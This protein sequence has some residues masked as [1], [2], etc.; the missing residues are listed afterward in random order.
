M[1]SSSVP[2]S[3]DGNRA[4]VTRL[5]VLLV[6][7][8]LLLH[9]TAAAVTPY[10]FHRDELLYFSMGTHLR[11]FHMD[12][13]P[14]IALASELLRHTVGVSVFTYRMM[15]ALAGAASRAARRAPRPR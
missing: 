10:E 11:L 2:G 15:P 14:L 7:I 4:A 12:F 1:G 8:K 5:V 3:A 13:P 6:G 9:V